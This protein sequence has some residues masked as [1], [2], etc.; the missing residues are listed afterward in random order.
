MRCTDDKLQLRRATTLHRRNTDGSRA[1][2][3]TAPPRRRAAPAKTADE[4]RFAR[5]RSAEVPRTISPAGLVRQ[6]KT[7]LL[8]T[9]PASI[10]YIEQ[11]SEIAQAAPNL[12]VL[13]AFQRTRR[14]S[15]DARA[16]IMSMANRGKGL[17][18]YHP[19]LWYNWSNFP[20]YNRDLVGGGA[21][22][23]DKYGEFEVEVLDPTHPM[24]AGLP[25][26]VQITDE[27]YH[28]VAD[29]Q[30]APIQ[31]LAQATSPTTGKTFP[32]VWVTRHPQGRI[33]CITLGHDGKARETAEFQTLLKN[34][35]VWWPE[36]QRLL[37]NSFRR[38]ALGERLQK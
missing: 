16:A 24:M 5:W 3:R 31:V 14:L 17:L 26:E 15:N 27:L 2:T 13:R 35:F 23:H 11:P 8:E 7:T 21:R 38:F 22:S 20:E 37:R 29:P 9:K 25:K 1:E 30:G 33:A 32:Q 10:D 19:A 36:K 4:S 34:A 18:L 12:D 6:D 28:V